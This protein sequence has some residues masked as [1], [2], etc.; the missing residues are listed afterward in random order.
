MILKQL[1]HKN[2]STLQ[3]DAMKDK[4]RSLA[5]RLKPKET[6]FFVL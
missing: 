1:Q 5:A 4:R 2:D 6:L 3:Q